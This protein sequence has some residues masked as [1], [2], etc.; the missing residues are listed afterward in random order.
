M[1]QDPGRLQM[2]IDTME[3]QAGWSTRVIAH[4][5]SSV[6]LHLR[7][8]SLTGLDTL[9]FKGDVAAGELRAIRCG[10][11]SYQLEAFF[12]GRGNQLTITD[13]GSLSSM[14]PDAL[15][16]LPFAVESLLGSDS[17]FEKRDVKED[18]N[19]LSADGEKGPIISSSVPMQ[20]LPPRVQRQMRFMA[21]TGKGEESRLFQTSIFSVVGCTRF[22]IRGGPR[23]IRHGDSVK[24]DFGAKRQPLHA[25]QVDRFTADT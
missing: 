15:I 2:F 19:S 17:P 12:N 18:L 7:V 11:G 6:P 13:M 9:I 4:N 23:C 14:A 24:Y 21:T 25:E 1:I 22:E 8:V 5:R 10:P 16:G 3:V 20:G